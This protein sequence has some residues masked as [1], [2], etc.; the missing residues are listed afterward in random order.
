M[1]FAQICKN[2]SSQIRLLP[3]K[4]YVGFRLFETAKTLSKSYVTDDIEGYSLVPFIH[5]NS[6]PAIFL[7]PSNE[8]VEGMIHDRFLVSQGLF[9]EA[10]GEE[11]PMFH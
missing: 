4:P 5:V 3:R 8:Q 9:G 7:K 1:V 10:V 2:V 11:A 6:I